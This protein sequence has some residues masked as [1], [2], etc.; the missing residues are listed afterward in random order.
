MT[1]PAGSRALRRIATAGALVWAL[2]AFAV[3]ARAADDELARRTLANADQLLR[4]GKI[5]QGLRDLEQIPRAYPTS[6]VA[7]DALYRIGSY[8]YPFE[9]V[10]DLGHASTDALARAKEAFATV[11]AKY[12]REDA[13]PG[14]LYK[15]GLIALD[16]VNPKRNLDEAYASFT[17][18]VNI[19]PAS[20][21]VGPALF[22]MGYSDFEAGRY[23]K[24]ITAFEQVVDRYAGSAPAA[25]ALYTMGM[26][27]A[28]QAAWTRSLET[29]QLLRTLHPKSPLAGRALDRMT[30]IYKMKVQPGVS[31]G[32]LFV[33]DKR[34]A[35]ALP[36]EGPRG[37][38]S[39]AVDEKSVVHLLD[40]R[41]GTVLRLEES[42]AGSLGPPFESATS[43]AMDP[44]GAEILAAGDKLRVGVEVIRPHV[45]ERGALQPLEKIAAAV[46]AGP[47][48]IALLDVGR[49][50]VYLYTGDPSR[51]DLLY[52]DPAGRA[53]LTGLAAGAEGRLYTIDRRSRSI[54]DIGADR[55]VRTIDLATVAP[56][57]ASDPV[58]IAADGL[59]DLFVLDRR[60]DAVAVITTEGRL[61]QTIVSGEGSA[62]FSYPSGIAV[63]P[64][65]ELYIYD[66]KRKTI[67]RFR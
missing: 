19:Y 54:I 41:A 48:R 20:D 57:A 53:R 43:I 5:E 18:V 51:L 67:L 29:L 36:G 7:D 64:R 66:E 17:S 13:A 55:R 30:L 11:T 38:V 27:F 28:R 2:L 8:Y 21:Q 14:A 35:P 49:N 24:A 26:A 10:D 32:P 46:S 25:E 6:G 61:L 62:E 33:F 40:T 59:G 52:R 47:G 34:Y 50:E 63:G 15:L 31:S 42:G 60:S 39:L 23:D 37:A 16:P 65:A 12:P 9:T 44:A 3:T 22:G 4:E 56:G 58:D 45:T 1:R